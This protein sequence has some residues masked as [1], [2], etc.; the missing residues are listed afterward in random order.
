MSPA[1]E[2]GGGDVTLVRRNDDVRRDV[3]APDARSAR[4]PG[5]GSSSAAARC[6]ARK[7]WRL[8]RIERARGVDA[9]NARGADI[10]ARKGAGRAVS[11][12]G[13]RAL[14]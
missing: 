1:C 2:R 13:V 7:R 11:L 6:Y 4:A 8:L 12:A 3:C 14:G 5:G 9:M 10:R